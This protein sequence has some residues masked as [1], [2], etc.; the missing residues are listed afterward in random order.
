MKIWNV[1]IIGYAHSHIHS[2]ALDFHRCGERVRFVAGADVRPLV[3]PTNRSAGTRYGVMEATNAAI[4]LTNL[5][6]DYHE[7]LERERFDIILC[8]AENAFHADVCEAVLS[9]GI[10]VVVE[11]PLAVTMEQAARIA[12]AAQAGGAEVF[13]NWP[14]TWWN[15]VREAQRLVAA[16]A[17]GP[18]YKM[19]YRNRDSLGPLSYGQ[20]MT[21]EEMGQEW[22]YQQ[23]AGGGALLDYCCY[24]ANLSRWFFGTAPQ[25]CYA[26]ARNFN[27]PFGDTEDYATITASY[28]DGIA[29]IEGSWVTVNTG[30][31]YG[32]ILYGRDATLVVDGDEIRIYRTRHAADPDE[33]IEVGPLPA[34]RSTLGEE[35]LHHLETG[36][37]IHPTLELGLNL[38]AQMVLD[39]GIRSLA[40]GQLEATRRG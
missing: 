26:M 30:I 14:S 38:E 37:P 9:R 8:C 21:P 40:S 28:P 3:E 18:L 33:V 12:R 15:S 5:Y 25:A 11:K 35:V 27:S 32:P 29:I 36:E 39:A 19:T 10:H 6:D 24:G 23:A 7:M 13:V 1:G 4:G 34:G 22:W 16:G 17:I 31:P 2:N 20:V